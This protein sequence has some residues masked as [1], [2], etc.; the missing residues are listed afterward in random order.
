MRKK[1]APATQ[2]LLSESEFLDYRAVTLD[3]F[4]LEVTEK[5]SSLTYHFE[6]TSAAVTVIGVLLHVVSQLVYSLCEN[7]N[8]R[9]GRA[10]LG[11]VSFVLGDPALLLFLVKHSFHLKKIF[12]AYIARQS[13]RRVK[14]LC[15]KSLVS[16]NPAGVRIHHELYHSFFRL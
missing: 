16:A 6:K 4:F 10:C 14:A 2:K 11:I 7:S 3:V 8:L 12:Y 9:F 15:K 1:H 13:R 5:I